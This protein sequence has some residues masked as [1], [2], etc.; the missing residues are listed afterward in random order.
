MLFSSMFMVKGIL[1]SQTALRT[2]FVRI[3]AT[4]I[5]QVSSVL[6][7]GTL[8]FTTSFLCAQETF[9]PPA[10]P[11]YVSATKTN[12]SMQV[13][14]LL[15]EPDWE[16]AASISAF[17]QK[18]PVQGDSISM[19]TEVK[20]LFDQDYLYVGAFCHTKNGRKD[21]RVQNF[22]RDFSYFQNDLF[23]I[24]IDGFMDKRNC[25][26]FQTNPYGAQREILVMDDQIFNR[27]WS[28]LWK[29]RTQITDAGWTAEMAIPWKT[30]RYPDNCKQMGIILNRNIR[31]N[32]EYASYPAVPRAF[33]V[34]RM[35]YEAILTGIEPPP[36]TVNIQVNPYALVNFSTEK[37]DG[38]SLNEKTEIKPG[39]EVKW[40]MSPSSVLDLTFN[41]DF[42]QADVDRQVV[43]LTRFS[44]LFPERRQFFLEGNEIYYMAAWDNLQ[45]F[46]SRRI[47]L[48]DSGNPV[49]IQ[50]GAR[51]T[52]RSPKQSVGALMIRQSGQDEK[53]ASN[54]AVARYSRNLSGQNRLGGM[55]TFRY[56]E[57]DP[58]SGKSTANT[59]LTVDG[60]FRP[61]QQI[62]AFWMLSGSKTTGAIE[63][64][65]L[66]GALWAYYSN[67]WIYLGHVQS[68]ITDEYNPR[69]GFVDATNYLVTSPAVRFKLRPPWL[70]KFIR[71]YSPGLTTY[72]FHYLDDLTFR[73]GF[74]D[75]Q[76]FSLELQD[77]SEF[78]YS[79]R[80]TQQSLRESFFPVGIEIAQGDYNYLSHRVSY[81]SDFS[82]KIAFGANYRFGQYFD[83]QLNTL[84]S[85]LRLAPTP[86][87]ALTADYEWNEIRGLGFENTSLTTHLIG[88]ELR[89]ALNPRLQWVNFYQYN[90]VAKRATLNSRFVWEYKPLSY[91]YLVYN[92]NQ[93]DA[94]DPETNRTNR[95]QTQQGIF[96]LTFLRQF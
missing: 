91:I 66:S 4:D 34:Y 16:R 29:V 25:L 36:P 21:I 62:N 86:H 94:I 49:P 46:F 41:T 72:F 80:T 89:L 77:G 43:N 10:T 96:K 48:D 83:G 33:T 63:D 69:V 24:A 35:P 82:K 22:Q 11:S 75:Y 45:P 6:L 17:V 12:I 78:S 54:F 32:N 87:I 56:D 3:K 13:D 59:T 19:P 85:S 9:E 7:I 60:F 65:G 20:I 23:G 44:V 88:A 84:S 53:P 55:A 50:T 14:G 42:A 73:E 90:T 15:D 28:G 93:G 51:F 76:P 64:E 57:A 31:L 40:V 1:S 18:D 58:V 47:G 26:V 52:S 39:G 74:I 8:F 79:F 38:V 67:N 30:L 81:T 95:I 71:Q 2:R 27:E 5:P 37:K 92:D 70:P 61:T 68:F